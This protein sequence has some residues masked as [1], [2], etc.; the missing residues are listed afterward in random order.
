M[1][2][3][4]KDLVKNLPDNVQPVIQKNHLNML[5]GLKVDS[6]IKPK[7]GS[8]WNKISAFPTIVNPSNKRNSSAQ[9]NPASAQAAMRILW[10]TNYPRWGIIGSISVSVPPTYYFKIK[11]LKYTNNKKYYLFLIKFCWCSF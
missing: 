6:A 8:I 11:N 5:L 2:R 9:K 3:I 4:V 1:G 10:A 7:L